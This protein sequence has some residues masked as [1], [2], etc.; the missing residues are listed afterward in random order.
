[1]GEGEKIVVELDGG[2][3][4]RSGGRILRTISHCGRRM[5]KAILRRNA[6]L[7]AYRT[8]ICRAPDFCILEDCGAMMTVVRGDASAYCS[9]LETICKCAGASTRRVD[10][11]SGSCKHNL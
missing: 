10:G 5:G 7:E 6:H 8:C 11:F 1:M 9:F 3:R 4:V 2:T